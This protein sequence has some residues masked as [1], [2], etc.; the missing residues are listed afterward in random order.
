MPSRFWIARNSSPI[1]RRS[2]A[3]RLLSGSSSSSTFGLEHQRAR[4]RD[5]L[6]LAAGQRRRRPLGEILH[7]DQPQ[8]LR[9]ALA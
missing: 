9:D 6:L 4:D 1:C 3:S 8:R 2:F 7:F 5:A